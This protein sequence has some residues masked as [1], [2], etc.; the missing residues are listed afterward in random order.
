MISE[1]LEAIL[2]LLPNIGNLRNVIMEPVS[3]AGR[4]LSYNDDPIKPWPLLPLLSSE[5][6]CGKYEHT[7]PAVIA[8]Q[9]LMVAG[10]VFDDIEDSDSIES[11]A[12]KY[13]PAVAINAATTL[14]ILAEKAFIRLKLKGVPDN[15]TLRVIDETN[16]FFV[17][18]CAGQHLDII[19]GSNSSLSE[20]DYFKIVAMKSASQIECACHV[21][22]TLAT[23]DQAIIRLFDQFGRNLGMAAQI[24]NDI[25]GIHKGTD[26][27]NKKITLPVIF[28]LAHLEG[29]SRI[30]LEQAY[31][32]SDNRHSVN[33]T[34]VKE[35][36]SCS[37]ALHYAT[38]RMECHTQLARDILSEVS[39]LGVITDKLEMFLV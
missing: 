34:Q 29:E 10:D 7:I 3:A 35:I 6:I 25:L 11:I 32:E 21:G 37:G 18:A 33:S 22:A 28:A 38:L 9:F 1:E 12:H 5:A 26:I 23:N 27:V 20:D 24:Y 2:A 14:I 17:T 31:H 16:Q 13:G 36:L 15:T 39:K 30:F 19:S 8:L 4:G